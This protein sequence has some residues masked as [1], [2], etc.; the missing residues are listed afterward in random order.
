MYHPKLTK[1]SMAGAEFKITD[2]ISSSIFTKLEK[3]SKDL[4][5]LDDDFK[6]TSNS[7]ADFA[8]KLAIQ[9]NA[10][11]GNLSELDKKS[12]EYEQTVKKLHDTQNKL[13]DLQQK[14]KE[15]LKQVNEV[16]KQAVN[17]AQEDAKAKKLNAEAELKLEKAQTERLRQ[18]KL[19]DQ[20]QTKN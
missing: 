12:K 5:T 16:T 8:S 6:R 11:P 4:K 13:A 10:S 17:N 20:E 9:I 1:S 7:Y 15:S 18:Q 19:L 3:L 2:E 14:Y